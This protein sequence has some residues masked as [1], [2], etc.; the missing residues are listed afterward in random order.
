[1]T[2]RSQTEMEMWRASCLSVEELLCLQLLGYPHGQLYVGMVNDGSLKTVV[3]E[4]THE[5]DK[6]KRILDRQAKAGVI[7]IPYYAET[8]P[9]H[10]RNLGRDAPL[11]IHI[12][13]NQALLNRED[14][15]AI[16]GARAADREGLDISYEFAN[17][18]GRQG[19]VVISGLALGCDTA[20][21]GKQT[22]ARRDRREVRSRLIRASFRCESQSYEVGGPLP[23]TSGTDPISHRGA[24]PH[25]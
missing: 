16:I 1:M 15:V 11:L 21:Q 25:H 8:Y 13:G 4:S 18:M 19:H 14:N 9:R 2:K 6:A 5:L 7:T 12:L 3:S 24:M 23:F 17:Q 20:A 10:F 22:V